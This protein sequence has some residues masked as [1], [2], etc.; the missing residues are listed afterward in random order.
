MVCLHHSVFGDHAGAF[1]YGKDVSLHAFSGNIRTASLIDSGNLVN[2]VKKDNA[3][4]LHPLLRLIYDLIHL[5]QFLY[6][7]CNENLPGLFHHHF[8]GFP[9]LRKHS[10]E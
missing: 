6:L 9:L 4:L 7:L 1:Y 2:F 5:D 3:R 8:P 10:T